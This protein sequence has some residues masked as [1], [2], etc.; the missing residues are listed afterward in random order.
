M[1]ARRQ[2]PGAFELALATAVA[3]RLL[4]L[5]RTGSSGGAMSVRIV[6]GVHCE[7]L[8]ANAS[9]RRT[10]GALC[11]LALR[12]SCRRQN[13]R[14]PKARHR[15][16][17]LQIGLLFGSPDFS[18]LPRLPRS[19]LRQAHHGFSRLVGSFVGQTTTSVGLARYRARLSPWVAWDWRELDENPALHSALFV[20]SMEF[21]V[22][23]EIA[24]EQRPMPVPQ[25]CDNAVSPG[26]NVPHTPAF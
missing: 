20:V 26:P 16:R 6:R 5:G 21:R 1:S 8:P 4:G 9:Q 11:C 2:L 17:L 12:G 24:A 10:S 14:V 23:G 19:R 18:I 15:L 22:T 7:L 13:L 25:T 3:R